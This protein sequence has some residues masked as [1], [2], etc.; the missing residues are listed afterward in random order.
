MYSVKILNGSS[1][2]EKKT[3]LL[4]RKELIIRT[5]YT[6]K[7]RERDKDF[8]GGLVMEVAPKVSYLVF[9]STKKNCENVAVF[10]VDVLQGTKR[11]MQKHK[12]EEKLI[13]L[14]TLITENGQ[15][16]P[17]LR[18]TIPFGFAYHY[19]GLTAEERRLVEEAFNHCDS[20]TQGTLSQ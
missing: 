11:E 17:I 19:S 3:C 15:I 13:L 10:L 8:L 12:T 1:I 16:C 5:I 14:N 2:K 20:T 4:E 7:T 18:K 6:E 9:C